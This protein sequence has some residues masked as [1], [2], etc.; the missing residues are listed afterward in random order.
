M[1]TIQFNT[2]TPWCCGT[3]SPTC[4][5]LKCQCLE[6]KAHRES[7]TLQETGIHLGMSI[8]SEFLTKD[9]NENKLRIFLAFC[10]L[11]VNNSLVSRCKTFPVAKSDKVPPSLRL[12]NIFQQH[13]FIFKKRHIS[14]YLE[15]VSETSSQSK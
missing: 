13:T 5:E 14:C 12:Q 10:N 8:S 3:V 2:Y 7:V 1:L 6:G 11:L 15:L 4:A 9:S